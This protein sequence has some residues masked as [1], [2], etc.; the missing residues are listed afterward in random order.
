MQEQLGL[1]A[2]IGEIGGGQRRILRAVEGLDVSPFETSYIEEEL[3]ASWSELRMRFEPLWQLRAEV[4]QGE[5]G[6]RIL[7]EIGEDQGIKLFRSK[8][9]ADRWKVF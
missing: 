9:C 1:A 2:E 6:R 4:A 5:G 3:V 8:D 7:S